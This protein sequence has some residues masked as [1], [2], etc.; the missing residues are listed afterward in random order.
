M[1]QNTF[2][3]PSFE[4][5]L[6]VICPKEKHC[7]FFYCKHII[8]G[9]ERIRAS[10]PFV[11]MALHSQVVLVELASSLMAPL[12]VSQEVLKKFTILFHSYVLPFF[13]LLISIQFFTSVRYVS[14]MDNCW[15]LSCPAAEKSD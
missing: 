9:E 3:K 12:E 8:G 6:P 1:L 13:S 11:N 2:F 4:I 5:C 10:F 7:C 15:T 14:S